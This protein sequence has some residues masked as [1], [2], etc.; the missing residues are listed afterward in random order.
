MDDHNTHDS[1][2]PVKLRTFVEFSMDVASASPRRYL[3]E[4][5]CSKFWHP[6]YY[7]FIKENYVIKFNVFMSFILCSCLSFLFEVLNLALDT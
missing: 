2:I 1:R 4:V 3:F 7:A 5:R 6:F